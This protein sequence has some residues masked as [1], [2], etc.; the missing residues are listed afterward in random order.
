MPENYIAVRNED[1]EDEYGDIIE[2]KSK[3]AD[4][5]PPLPNESAWVSS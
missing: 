1:A 2:T 3:N 4:L 5:H